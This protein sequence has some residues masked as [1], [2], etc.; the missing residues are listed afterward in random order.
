MVTLTLHVGLHKTGTTAFQQAMAASRL[1]LSSRGIIYPEREANH[2]LDLYT[3][4]GSRLESYLPHVLAGRSGRDLDAFRQECFAA[5]ESMLKA[6]PPEAQVIASA[7]DMTRLSLEEWQSAYAFFKPFADTIRVVAVVREPV[8]WSTSSL[9]QSVKGGEVL[10]DPELH[11]PLQ[12]VE[13]KLDPVVQVAGR[14]NTSVFVFDTLAGAEGGLVPA[15]AEALGVPTDLARRLDAGTRNLSLSAPAVTLL[16]LVNERHPLRQEASN[17][18][19]RREGDFRAFE[20]IG[21]PPFRLSAQQQHRVL[22]QWESDEAFLE[23][24][25]GVE[26]KPVPRETVENHALAIHDDGALADIGLLVLRGWRHRRAL[27]KVRRVRD[28]LLEGR[29][30]QR[31]IL[32]V[33]A[34]VII[35]IVAYFMGAAFAFG[36]SA[37]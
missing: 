13:R 27:F 34:A 18:K 11:V 32:F 20:R 30:R 16:S 37:S 1:E 17:G 25:F 14:E 15:L 35:A 2:S 10:W 4:F 22:Q 3:M 23:R 8:A 26:I 19:E 29:K 9:Q 36:S 6:A 31:A 5:W 24:T 21:G 7:E 33:Q 12:F 28:A